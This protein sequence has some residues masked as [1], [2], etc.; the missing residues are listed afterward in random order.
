MQRD[1]EKTARRMLNISPEATGEKKPMPQHIE[2]I[3]NAAERMLGRS[4][5]RESIA[6]ICAI[7]GYVESGKFDFSGFNIPSVGKDSDVEDMSDAD[8]REE[9]KKSKLF[10][11]SDVDRADKPKLIEM[12]VEVKKANPSGK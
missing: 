10:K 5:A 12:L 11:A 8:L 6:I 4:P 9:V 2:G 3:L 1:T 7:A